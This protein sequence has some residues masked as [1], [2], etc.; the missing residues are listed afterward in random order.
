MKPELDSRADLRRTASRPRVTSWPPLAVRPPGIERLSVVWERS[1][2]G[3]G[4]EQRAVAPAL[5][6]RA[7]AEQLA[8]IEALSFV[9]REGRRT[10]SNPLRVDMSGP[11]SRFAPGFLDDVIRQGYRPDTAAKQLQLMAHLSRWLAARELQGA[12]LTADRLE[13]F[14]AE[15]R[16]DHLHY[17]SAKGIS[18]LVS[19]LRGFGGVP[20]AS[21]IAARTPSELLI[22]RYSAYL[23]RETRAVPVER[24]QLRQCRTRVLHRSRTDTRRAR[25]GEA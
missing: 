21:P 5:R 8:L 25:A 7:A 15:R 11:L 12:D 24:A 3:T 18:P 9:H 10:M 22:V 1:A 6:E 19:Y 23:V 2:E 20:A 16:G 17:F 4:I 14:L 13:Q